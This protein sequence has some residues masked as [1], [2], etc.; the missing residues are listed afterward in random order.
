[1]KPLFKPLLLLLFITSA[2]SI[3]ASHALGGEIYWECDPNNSGKYIFYLQVLRDCGG[4]VTGC[5]QNGGTTIDGPFG[6]I[7]MPNKLIHAQDISPDCRNSSIGCGTTNQTGKGA[8]ELHLW[9]SNPITLNGVP[10]ANTGWTFSWTCNARPGTLVNGGA[11]QNYVLRAKMYRYTP[12]GGNPSNPQNA[13][14]CFDNSP[15]FLESPAITVCDGPFTYNHLA[16]DKDLDSLYFK[17]AEPWSAIGTSIN[18]NAGYSFNSPLPSPQSNA[19]NGPLVLDGRTG[20]VSMNIQSA[21][22]GSYASCFAVEAWRCG[23]IAPG[24]VGPVLIAEV[25]RDIAIILRDD[26]DPVFGGV[27]NN[28]PQVTVD[29]QIYKNIKKVGNSYS[30]KVFPGDT[31]KFRFSAADQ[32]F[33]QG[34]FQSI[35]FTAAG[36]QVSQPLA[37]GFGC[38]GPAPCATFSP[39]APQVGYVKTLKNEQEFFWVPDC[40]HLGVAGNFCSPINK[41]NFSL[42][43]QDDGCPAPEI[44]LVTFTVEVV[45]GDPTP[46][47]LKCLSYVDPSGDI[48]LAWDSIP[49]DSGL[50]FNYYMVLGSNSLQ[51]PYDTLLYVTDRDSLSAI[52]PGGYYEHFFIQQST[53]KCDFLSTPSD[54]LSL[55]HLTLT[56]TPPGSAEYAGLVWTPLKKNLDPSTK[57]YEIWAEAPLG[58]GNWK[59]VDR[60]DTLTYVDTVNVCNALVNYQIR[61]TDTLTGCQSASTLDS[62]TFSDK[63]NKDKMVLDSVSVN[64]AGNAIISWDTTKYADVTNYYV[65]FND[66]KLGW[67]VVDTVARGTAMP[68]EWAGSQADVRSEEFKI[69]SVDSC[70]NQSDDQIV[71]PHASIHL[72]RYLNKCEAYLRLSWNAYEGF[73]KD[74]VL[75]YK[76]IMQVDGGPWSEL[77]TASSHDTSYIQRNLQ[78]GSVYCYRVQVTD[79]TGRTS[80]SNELCINA[81]V[82]RKSQ[83]LYLAQVTNDVDRGAVK[84]H[85]F[86]DS[87]ADV[88]EFELERAPSELGPFKSVGKIAKPAGGGATISFLDYEAL[89]DSRHYYYRFSATDSCGGRDTVSNLSRNILVHTKA[90]PNLTNLI[91]WNPYNTWGGI[92]DRYEVY[93]KSKEES[94]FK[95][96]GTTMGDDTTY[97]DDISDYRESV[98]S[99]CYYVV[100]IEGSNPVGYAQDNGQPFFSRS[101]ESCI[102]QGAKVYMA[103]AFR[104][105][106]DVI[107]N[108][109]YGPS[110]KFNEVS[111]YHFYIMNRWGVKVFETF[112]PTEKWDGTYNNS[113]AQQGVYIYFL[114]Y[115]AQGAI[116]KEER[117]DFT[118]IR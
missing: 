55:M 41:F 32:D 26:C 93:R 1:M 74:A 79:T 109:T 33:Y 48:R 27:P 39:V 4:G 52:V 7:Q 42:R 114:R 99:F 22:T 60:T 23:Q 31:V 37:S 44:S 29:T 15:R 14:P 115:S 9:K 50:N 51:G 83:V 18:W 106:S 91:T 118:L 96:A 64:G 25:Y 58:S 103:T 97:V 28:P 12:V 98:G 47:P 82:P 89:S 57:G 92:V 34:Q 87:Q 30:T 71:K 21:N 53:G 5:Y 45:P 20:E 66:P 16:A 62:A 72:K 86:I 68:Y 43:M 35:T 17:W 8:V 3:R 6:V 36:L 116:P 40:Q 69:I 117:G 63:T 77:Y 111:E 10:P 2:F 113:E 84:V 88:M 11:N 78:N 100:A 75:G 94:T 104:P 108:R 85:A 24:V 112:D 67:I 95:L 110:M 49:L 90:R 105:G 13:N 80:T 102:N 76:L 54:T 70:G 56:A 81:E 107:E 61:V 19:A 38:I 101:N 73:G 46:P 59:F 65:Y